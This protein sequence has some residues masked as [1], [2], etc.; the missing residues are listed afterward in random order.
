MDSGSTRLIVKTCGRS[1]AVVGALALAS[2]LSVGILTPVVFAQSGQPSLYPPPPPESPTVG[3]VNSDGQVNVADAVAILQ[4][5]VESRSLDTTQLFAA[6]TTGDGSVNVGDAVHILQYTVDPH[7]D[8]DVLAK[9][10]W[11]WAP[12]SGRSDAGLWDPLGQNS[13]WAE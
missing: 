7:G 13:G 10:L 9:P 12:E 4:Y 3:D 6:D 11:E 8:H 2:A 5:T 1:R